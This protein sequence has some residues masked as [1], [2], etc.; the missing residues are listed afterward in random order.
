MEFFVEVRPRTKGNHRVMVRDRRGRPRLIP[1]RAAR[2]VEIEL[3]LLLRPHAP[4]RPLSGPTRLDVD[5]V[6]PVPKSFTKAERAAAGA[7]QLLPVE[8]HHG[9]RGNFLKLIE[10]A[11]Q[12]ARFV[13]NDG[14]FCAGDVRKRFATA[15]DPRAGY[16]FRI[17]P[18]EIARPA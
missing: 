1:S 5:F 10:D 11:L 15:E 18:I 6:L 12:A 13:V 3:D 9:D 2:E 17:Q 8:A 4:R 16:W 14:Q 7:G